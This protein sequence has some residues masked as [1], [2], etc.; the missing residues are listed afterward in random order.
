MT[1]D[2]FLPVPIFNSNTHCQTML[3]LICCCYHENNRKPLNKFPSQ[4]YMQDYDYELPTCF[5]CTCHYLSIAADLQGNK[6]DSNQQA[7]L[8]RDLRL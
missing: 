4:S 6:A 5:T 3:S 1:H 8:D 2:Y 7:V